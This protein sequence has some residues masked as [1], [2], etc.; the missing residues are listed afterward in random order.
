MAYYYY[1]FSDLE[2]KNVDGMLCS[3]IKQL[4]CCR[5]DTPKALNDLRPYKERGHRPERE[6]L[7]GAL[8]SAFEGFSD[9]FLVVDALDECP[10]AGHELE[11]LLKCLSQILNANHANLHL[12]CTSRRELAI[13]KALEPFLTPAN[14]DIDLSLFKYK[15]G[16]DSDISRHV[17]KVFATETY[18]DWP[19]DIKMEAREALI[20]KADGM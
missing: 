7:M 4:C 18:Q 14:T 9:V 12:L 19:E 11:A 16:V 8:A 6:K 20:Q 13:E 10:T 3:L 17:D 15:A 1:S 2:K 5:L